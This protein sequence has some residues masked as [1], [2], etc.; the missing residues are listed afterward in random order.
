MNGIFI[1]ST[2]FSKNLSILIQVN[3]KVLY[4]L[5]H[6]NASAKIREC[7]DS[8][9]MEL[10]VL[11][12]ADALDEMAIRPI[13]AN[14]S[15][16]QTEPSSVSSASTGSGADQQSSVG[17]KLIDITMLSTTTSVQVSIIYIRI[18]L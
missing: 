16:S 8:Q 14:L 2:S 9:H 1:N 18:K 13:D 17:A 7:V 12:R 5:S 3:G 11:R 6:L 15:R 10:I 4:G